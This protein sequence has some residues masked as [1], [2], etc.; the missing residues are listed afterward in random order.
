MSRA[1]RRTMIRRTT[2]GACAL[3][4]ISACATPAP[5]LVT[6]EV[7]LGSTD[8]RCRPTSVRAVRLSAEGDFAPSPTDTVELLSVSGVR[9]LEGLRPSLL[10]LRAELDGEPSFRALGRTSLEEARRTG[11]LAV[12][13]LGTT[14]A[15]VD[16]DA[17]APDGAALVAHVDGS[18]W[19]V[20]GDGAERRVV[21]VD[22]RRTFADVHPDALFDRREAASATSFDRDVVI[23]GGAPGRTDTAYDSYE[24]LGEDVTPAGVGPGGRLSLPRRDHAAVRVGDRLVLVGGRSGGSDDALVARI[25]VVDLA[26]GAASLGPALATPRLHPTLALLDDGAIVVAGGTDLAGAPVTTLERIDPG[27]DRTHTLEVSLPE[28]DAIVG[29]PL[30]RLL[31]LS[32]GEVRLVDLRAE[33][34]RVDLLPR[35][36]ALRAP[37]AQVTQSGRVLLIGRD[38]E[39]ALAAELWT[40]HLGRV[41]VLEATQH[42][43][44]ALWLADGMALE[45][46]RS[47]ASLRALDEPGP[48]SSLPN[49]RLLFPTD[50]A[51]PFVVASAPG[52][53][54][55]ARATR[56]GARLAIA[57]LVLG[58]FSLELEGSGSRTLALR[59]AGTSV[60]IAL[61]AEGNAFGPGCTLTREGASIVV[62]RVGA[63]LELVDG[64][65]RARCEDV[66]ASAR[67]TLEVSLDRDASLTVL[68]LARTTR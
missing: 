41:E 13:P 26:A 62:T 25:D 43:E 63:R 48:W 51:S 3:L 12:L 15:L 8:P 36:S 67:F 58:T 68:H 64:S 39:G 37:H 21:R 50:L 5:D 49:D 59:D 6:L 46:D 22:A 32:S 66:S 54:D 1:L 35:V 40:P 34:A 23:A 61:D 29:L 11:V 18:G 44:G 17:F 65:R 20:G 33:P 45:I 42:P 7:R 31:V 2:L 16:P 56:S 60:E 28:A 53:F 30:D 14:C 4:A 57:P 10:T 9:D 27:L 24:R 38:R 52:D 19:I 47:G 55:G